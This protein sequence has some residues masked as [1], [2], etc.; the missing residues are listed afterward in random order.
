[1]QWFK[2]VDSLLL[3]INLPITPYSTVSLPTS[4]VLKQS[5]LFIKTCISNIVQ[6]VTVSEYI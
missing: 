3:F 4:D 2:T 6:V 5:L 1:M